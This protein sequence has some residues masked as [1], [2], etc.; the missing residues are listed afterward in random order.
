MA[1]ASYALEDLQAASVEASSLPV[2]PKL[3]NLFHV[4]AG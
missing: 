4:F 1:L 2:C 3:A